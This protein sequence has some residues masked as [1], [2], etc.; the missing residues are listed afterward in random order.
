MARKNLQAV[1]PIELVLEHDRPM[2][3]SLQVAKHFGKAH[4][5]VLRDIR[6]LIKELPAEWVSLNFEDISISTDL[7]HATRQDPAYLMT[8]DGFTLLAMG[9][10]GKRALD[11]KLK[12]IEAFNQMEMALRRQLKAEQRKRLATE[13]RLL[14]E[15]TPP[16]EDD[17]ETLRQKKLGILRGLL[18]K[19]AQLD[20]LPLEAAELA[21]CAYLQ[22]RDLEEMP[23]EQADNAHNFLLKALYKLSGKGG[24]ATEEQREKIRILV[25][26]CA[27]SRYVPGYNAMNAF[28]D[29]Y[30]EIQEKFPNG[31]ALSTKGAEKF[32]YFLIILQNDITRRDI[33]LSNLY[34]LARN[35]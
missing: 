18:V 29:F 3:S 12:Y 9:F 35:R 13:A 31:S 25:E 10:T 27:Q 20:H 19:W 1:Q 8:R 30:A 32:I 26:A 17:P 15:V 22:I 33:T 34:D 7:G 28:R 16:K 21:L 24:P 11:W 5:N 4:D 6:N 14:A 2:A 23:L